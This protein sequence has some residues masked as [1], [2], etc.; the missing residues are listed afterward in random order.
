MTTF[1]AWE[2]AV[3]PPEDYLMHFRTKGSKN[4]VRRYQNPDGTW[5]PLGLKERKEREGWGD[6]KK[7]QRLQKKLA[8]AENRQARKAAREQRRAEKA[9]IKRKRSLSG[10]TDEEM[11]AKLERAKM[12]AEYRELTKKNHAVLEAGA[13][14]VTKILDYKDNKEQRMIELNR[15]KLELVK[16][17][18]LQIQAHE[19][20]SKA[21]SE[22]LASKYEAKK[23]KQLRKQTE[24]DVAGGLANKRKAD[25][26][27]AKRQYKE[28]TL[29]GIIK[30]GI[31]QRQDDTHETKSA[32]QNERS[33]AKYNEKRKKGSP[34]LESPSVA[35]EREETAKRANAEAVAAQNANKARYAADVERYKA[36]QERHKAGT[37][38][39]ESSWK[40]IQAQTEYEK[41]RKKNKDKKSK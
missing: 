3:S 24:A 29:F 11:K 32:I 33:V 27:N 7:E 9:E 1:D 28:G 25:L 23:A 4:G 15:Q 20:S 16:Q 40:K 14:I 39:T 12:E 30:K 34:A 41:E 35:K 31:K 13:Q 5:T 10:L 17:R 38:A 36:D 21:K 26:Y 18:T 2:A 8:R 6:S 19:G 22:A 37:A